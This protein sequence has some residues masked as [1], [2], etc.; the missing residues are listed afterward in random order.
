MSSRIVEA[1]WIWKDGEFVRWR[2]ANVHLLSLAVQFGSSVF[3]GIRCYPTTRGPAIFRLDEHIRRLHG[4]CRIYRMALPWSQEQLMVAC[5]AAV[6]RNG[7]TECYLRPMVL[8]GYG[9]AGMNPVN[10]PIETYIPCWPWGTYLGPDALEAGVDAC[11]S[12]WQRP[13]PNTFPSTAKAAGHYNNAQLIKMEAVANGYAE[14]IA[15]GPGGLVSEG[16]GQ[17]VF[18]V[19]NGNLITPSLDGTSLAGITR[20]S[21]ITIARD[22]DITVYEQ[23][24]PREALYTADEAFFTGTAA[25]VTPIRSVD[26]IP[27]GAGRVGPMTR[28][29]QQRFMQTVHGEIEDQHRWLAYVEPARVREGVA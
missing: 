2:D 11:V 10:C 13:E 24:V 6:A 23:E 8:R 19:R 5:K 29:L 14:A 22:L 25:E 9:N 1:D 4:S 20:D 15:L 26:R 7:F 28:L 3:E 17:N 21:I 18:I 27:V 16:S 12:S